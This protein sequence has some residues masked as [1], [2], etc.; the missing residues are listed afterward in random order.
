M[1]LLLDVN[2]FM[3]ILERRAGW[4]ESLAVATPGEFLKATMPPG[5]QE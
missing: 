3:D 1:K 5:K 2:V 4:V